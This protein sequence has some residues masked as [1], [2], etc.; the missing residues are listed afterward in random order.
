M[1]DGVDV[2]LLDANH[3]PGAVVF[4]FKRKLE[5]SYVLHTVWLGVGHGVR[6]G[7]PNGRL[8]RAARRWEPALTL[9]R[10]VR[11]REWPPK[12]GDF[13]APGVVESYPELSRMRCAPENLPSH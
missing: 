1:V 6:L 4:L 13:R 2:T 9:A 12:Q 5:H 8:Q 3:C 11:V 7:T 10:R